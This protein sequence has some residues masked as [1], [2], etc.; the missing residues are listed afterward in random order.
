[1]GVMVGGEGGG[2]FVGG[3]GWWGRV[4]CVVGGR[5]PPPLRSGLVVG[6]GGVGWVGGVFGGG[7]EGF[8]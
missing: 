1:M 6:V 2:V 7:G 8:S 5:R 4:G 3:V